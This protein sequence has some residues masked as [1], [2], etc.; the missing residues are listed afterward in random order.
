MKGEKNI[1]RNHK[2]KRIGRQLFLFLKTAFAF[3]SSLAYTFDGY[4]FRWVNTVLI[5]AGGNS[6]R[7]GCNKLLEFL[8][9][10]SVIVRSV[11]KFLDHPGVSQVFVVGGEAIQKELKNFSKS[12]LFGSPGK[13]RYESLQSGLFVLQKYCE[14]KHI[15]SSSVKVLVHNGANPFVTPEEIS[16]VLSSLFP[17]TAVAVGRQIFGTI[18]RISGER[19]EYLPREGL[20]EMETPQGA[21]LS[22]FQEWIFFWNKHF[23]NEIPTDELELGIRAGASPVI[24]PA[25][26]GNRK[27]T[28]REDISLLSF[29]SKRE[30]RTGVGIDSHAFEKEKKCILCGIEIPEADGF[31]ANSDGDVALHAL[32]NALSSAYGGDSFSRIADPLCKNGV[33]DSAVYLSEIFNALLQR[34]G[35]IEHIAIAFEGSR[36]RLERHFLAMRQYLAKLLRISPNSIGLTATSG[37]GIELEEGKALR[38]VA[39]A[40]VSFVH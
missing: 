35:R 31:S 2:S 16:A 33:T 23:I 36:P 9:E 17:N 37:E 6:E 19:I 26:I 30:I 32:S 4:F 39:I 11:Q 24:L 40:T 18:R 3:C 38:V 29:L 12:L 1:E 28:R 21:M 15:P 5:L 22:D 14:E 34:G 13:N 10:K 27:I 25:A 7:F 20:V 8:G